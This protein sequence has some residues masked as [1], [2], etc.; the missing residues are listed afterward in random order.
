MRRVT[1]TALQL[2][3]D[4]GMVH[5]RRAIPSRIRRGGCAIEDFGDLSRQGGNIKDTP[6][7]LDE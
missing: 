2:L 7:H 1:I 4:D 6:E 3:E 5:G